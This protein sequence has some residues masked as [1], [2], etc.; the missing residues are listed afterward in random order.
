MIPCYTCL[1]QCTPA[2]LARQSR[3][4]DPLRTAHRLYSII[5][6]KHPETI[7]HSKQKLQIRIAHQQHKIKIKSLE[8]E[9]TSRY[10]HADAKITKIGSKTEKLWFKQDFLQTNNRLD[11]SS[12]YKSWK[13]TLQQCNRVDYLITNPTQFERVKSELKQ[14]FYG[15]N[16]SSGKTVN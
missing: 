10:E 2:G 5:S 3:T 12:Y 1:E 15:L 16:K 8:N 6:N 7:M 4:L 11:L 14:R 13:P 9:S